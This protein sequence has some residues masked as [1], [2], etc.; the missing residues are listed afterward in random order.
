MNG[1]KNFENGNGKWQLAFWVVTVICG[2][3]FVCLTS[4]VIANERIRVADNTSIRAT[5]TLQYTEI[6]QRLTRIETKM[7]VKHSGY[8]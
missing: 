4:G 7:E 6:I 2:V 3:W 5:A 8:N 1:E